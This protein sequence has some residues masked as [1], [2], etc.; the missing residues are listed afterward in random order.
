VR[1]AETGGE[2][3]A[4]AHQVEPDSGM[5]ATASIGGSACTEIIA[6]RFASTSAELLMAGV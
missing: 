5:V 3:M 1:G 6:G 4:V 2:W